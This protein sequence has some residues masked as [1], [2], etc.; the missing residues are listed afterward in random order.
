MKMNRSLLSGLVACGL[1]MAMASSLLAQTPIQGAA[2]V[3]RIRGH[4]RY[5]TGSADW[6][7]LHVGDL[8]KAGTL[9][10]TSKEPDGKGYVDLSLEGDV[11]AMTTGPRILDT[12]P[13]D[14]NVASPPSIYRY[15]PSASQNVIRIFDNTALGVDKLSSMNTGSG[16]VTDT[17]LDL[18]TGHIFVNVKKLSA[19]SRYEVK[20]PTGV[21]GIRGSSAEFFAEGIIKTGS[22]TKVTA[23]YMDNNNQAVTTDM[24]DDMSLDMRTGALGPLSPT[25]VSSISALQRDTTFGHGTSSYEVVYSPDFTVYHPMSSNNNG[26]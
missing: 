20:M 19:G 9:I 17:E 10:Q 2:K 23:A 14:F 4:A 6:Q 1:A 3:V 21:A 18:K 11:V 15:R 25:D 13:A 7:Q 26:P 16:T 24:T 8:V 22:N 5:K 12:A